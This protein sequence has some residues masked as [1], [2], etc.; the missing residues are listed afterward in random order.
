MKLLARLIN[1]S[2]VRVNSARMLLSLALPQGEV[3][4][5]QIDYKYIQIMMKTI[6]DVSRY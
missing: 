5:G 4:I 6:I 3:S 1:F 2:R